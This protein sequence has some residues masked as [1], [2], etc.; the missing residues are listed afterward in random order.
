MRKSCLPRPDRL[1]AGAAALTLFVAACTAPAPTTTVQVTTTDPMPTTTV[2]EVCASAFCIIYHIEPEAAWSDG[3]PVTADDFVHTYQV[4]RS[5]DGY[6]SIWR[7]EAIDAKTVLFE[8]SQ[9][10]GPWQTLFG[11]VL[12]AHVDDPLSVSAAPFVLATMGEEIVLGRNPRHRSVGDVDTIRFSALSSVRDGLRRL[13]TGDLDVIF[14]PSLDWVLAELDSFEGVERN[15]VSGSIWEQIA[16]NL[17][18]PLLGQSWLREA[19]N[20]AIDRESL[21]DS[22]IRVI[23]EGE[24][25][26]GSAIWPDVSSLYVDV[27]PDAFDPD[28]ALQLLSGQGCVRE[29]DGVFSCDG[30]RLSFVFATTIGD[31]WRRVASELI[32]ND[33]ARVGIEM[34]TLFLAPAEL[35]ADDFLFGD[36]ETWDLI[37]F[38]WSFSESLHLGDS[39]FSCE[40]TAPSGFGRLN[41]NRFCDATVEDLVAALQTETSP[42]GRRDLY[43]E[44]DKV[45]LEHLAVIP[46]YQR[47]VTIAWDGS[48][49]GPH[50]NM[51]R[52]T[53][54]WNIGDWVGATEV[55]VGVGS[56]PSSLDLLAPGDA[57]LIL[58]P[59]TA[60]AFSVDPSLRFVPMLISSAETISGGP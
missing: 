29:G 53:H 25:A 47:P 32:R 19:M 21:L 30:E 57:T 4:R 17:D 51:S 23:S 11:V 1:Y 36:G 43:R 35:F 49:E 44:I 22:T 37:G 39:R 26:L 50:V 8:F 27:F 34:Q 10:Y 28:R 6:S 13:A 54:L 12:P 15:T 33:L 18:D 9:P 58:A 3:V 40:G 45:Y 16:F 7:H 2:P 46:L 52:S 59:V 5:E 38:P 24:P 42:R 20:L 56:L 60:G 14:P 48:I 55:S 31:P 41:V